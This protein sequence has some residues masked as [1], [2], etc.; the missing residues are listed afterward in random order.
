MTKQE[1][2][3]QLRQKLK[4][5]P[6]PDIEESVIFYTE[7]IDDRVEDG[8]SEEDAVSEIGSIDEIVSQTV[9]DIPLT[10]IVKEKV[11]SKSKLSALQIVLLAIGSPIW[12]SLLIALFA[13]VFSFWVCLWAVVITLWAV[14]VALAASSIGALA[15]GVIIIIKGDVL[16]GFFM[17]GACL[18]CAGLF[19]FLLL[20]CKAL[21]KFS[22]ILTKKIVLGIKKSFIGK[23][24][25]K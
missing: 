16:S 17:L 3:A 21:T 18:V 24:D 20:G 6:Q 5:L 2:I 25:E 23:E 8:I 13:V 9:S 4:G 1:F 19:I 14:D 11:R 7:M 22:A 10:K 12:V 15:S